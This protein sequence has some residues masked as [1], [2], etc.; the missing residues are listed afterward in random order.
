MRPK[1]KINYILQLV[2]IN[3]KE[4]IL[5]LI[6]KKKKLTGSIVN[7]FMLISVNF[8]KHFPA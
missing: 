7:L 4:K 2:E 5:V 8:T 3:M 6:A 1:K